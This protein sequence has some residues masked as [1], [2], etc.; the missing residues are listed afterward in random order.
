MEPM[1]ICLLG[2]DLLFA[3]HAVGVE[4]MNEENGKGS[5]QS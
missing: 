5:S 4:G 2:T 1:Q 3:V